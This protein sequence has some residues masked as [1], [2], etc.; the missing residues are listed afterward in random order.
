MIPLTS[1]S[2]LRE[3]AFVL[4]GLRLLASILAEGLLT[5][6]HILC[7]P[8]RER[9][10]KARMRQII[11]GRSGDTIGRSLLFAV[12]LFSLSSC[13]SPQPG[14]SFDVQVRRT[15]E[16]IEGLL[17]M[18]DAQKSLKSDLQDLGA[19]P[20]FPELLWDIETLFLSPEAPRSLRSDL[21]D[22][23]DPEP[24]KLKETVELLGW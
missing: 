6:G 15:G 10:E 22:L 13:R 20:S 23:A 11:L 5:L 18:P 24:G 7:F 1:L 2:L 9:A 3:I 14:S 17:A 19:P 8:F 21:Q 4:R 16:S 12:V